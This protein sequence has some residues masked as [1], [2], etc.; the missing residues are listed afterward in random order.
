MSETFDG[1]FR[2]VNW[3]VAG[4]DCRF[5]G[6]KAEQAAQF[7][8]KEAAALDANVITLQE[9]S[10]MGLYE[11]AERLPSPWRSYPRQF[12]ESLI[13]TCVQGKASNVRW[14]RLGGTRYNRFTD[15]WGYVQLEYH[16]VQITNVHTRAH[17][18]DAHVKELHANVKTGLVAGDFNHETPGW[19]Q[20][21]AKLE[22]TH[23]NGKIDH[24]LTVEKPRK[25]SGD[26]RSKG[27]SN[28]KVV[29][30]TVRLGR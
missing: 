25:A 20:T 10:G 28:H 5:N 26:A 2:I 15:W 24:I 30:A 17:W 12:G 29:V 7:I 1:E 13:V 23:S 4:A 14:Q 6:G 19:H 8:V 22:P 11:L 16:G 9:L 27:G 3:N 21:A 18:A